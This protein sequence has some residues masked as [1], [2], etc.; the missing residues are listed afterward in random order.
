MTSIICASIACY[1][2]LEL[3]I[4]ICTTFHSYKNLY[5]WSMV[6]ATLGIFPYVVGKVNKPHFS[7]GNAHL[8]LTGMELVLFDQSSKLC[9]L[10]VNNVGWILMVVAQNV[11]LY[12]RLGIVLGDT[13]S[14]ILVFTKWMIIVNAVIFYTLATVIVFG[15]HYSGNS[16]FD[17][18]Y[19]YV[20]RLQMTGT[21]PDPVLNDRFSVVIQA[22]AS[23]NSSYQDSISG[24]HLV[25]FKQE[26]RSGLIGLCGSFSSSMLSSCFLM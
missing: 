23:K 20:E 12:S 18:G 1:N 10:I 14:R 9:G 7:N 17:E 22:S 15:M 26:R 21:V 16:N 8:K 13:K 24:K 3:I 2:A 6:I 19:V 5:L 11:V 25:F 4:L